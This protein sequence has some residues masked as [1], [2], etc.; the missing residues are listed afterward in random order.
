MKDRS[1]KEKEALERQIHN[2]LDSDPQLRSKRELI[3]KFIKD[4]LR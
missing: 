4:N 2:L 1:S 3:K